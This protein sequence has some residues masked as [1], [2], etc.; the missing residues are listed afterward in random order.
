M[1]MEHDCMIKINDTLKAKVDRERM[2]EL[3]SADFK[4]KLLKAELYEVVENFINDKADIELKILYL[5]TQ[6]FKRLNPVV[7][8]LMQNLNISDDKMDEIWMTL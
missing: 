2:P 8:E 3:D 5:N 7:I 1:D 6:K 4:V